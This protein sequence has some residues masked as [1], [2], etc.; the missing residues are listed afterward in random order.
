MSTVTP[1]ALQLVKKYSLWTAGAGLIPI[2]FA[3]LAGMT[4][5]QLKMLAELTRLYGVPFEEG[6]GKALIGAIAG[7]VAS[8]S[9]FHGVPGNLVRGIPVLNLI[10][11]FS[12]PLIAGLV[13]YGVGSV[14]IAHFEKGGTLA[15]LDPSSPEARAAY[16][17]GMRKGREELRNQ[18]SPA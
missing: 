5:A 14:F 9:L 2:P 6:R 12:R 18:V 7:G 4:A 8:Y 3:D 10:G 15:D 1:A 17:E 11:L 13:S 16:E